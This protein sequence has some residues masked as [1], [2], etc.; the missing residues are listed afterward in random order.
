MVRR[1][2]TNGKKRKTLVKAI[3]KKA[4]AK[5]VKDVVKKPTFI[6]KALRAAGAIGGGLIG[7]P[8]TGRRVG[9]MVSKAIGQGDYAIAG[10]GI[11]MPGGN[12]LASVPSFGSSGALTFSHK[13]YIGDIF[14]G[15]TLVNGQ[16]A[17]NYQTFSLNPG[18]N[19]FLPVLSRIAGSF[20]EYE[21]KQL[22]IYY[23]STSGN[24]L[25]SANTAL[26]TVIL[27]TNY[28]A[29]LP[30]FPNKI[31]QE[32]YEFAVSG[33][34]ACDII[35]AV[36]CKPQ[37]NVLDRLYVRTD[38][39]IPS[40]DLRFSDLGKFQIST[41]GMQAANVNLGELWVSYTV[42]LHKPK[43]PT[44]STSISF[45]ANAS[46][47]INNTSP[48]GTSAPVI[49]P[50]SSSKITVD[51]ANNRIILDKTLI[52]RT[53]R[54]TYQAVGTGVYG[55]AFTSGAAAT[56]FYITGANTYNT[57]VS[58]ISSGVAISEAVYTLGSNAG[59]DYVANITGTATNTQMSISVVEVDPTVAN[60]GI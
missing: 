56:S 46:G 24:A 39:Q 59:A 10:P 55:T 26:G 22:M 38:S 21:W 33:K 50:N 48:L 25:T 23:R 16:T 52:G 47:T 40:T 45:L 36:E 7:F 32:N 15:P 43:I 9:A 11:T 4:E 30:S 31:L 12:N 27:S 8:K 28:N 29:N 60:R 41:I 20:E 18:L 34:P 13:E 17:F 5:I 53:L 51:Y 35:H 19:S 57:A 37:H 1:T 6:G 2:Q 58:Y 54:F 3:A 14:S 42:K 44:S 49:S